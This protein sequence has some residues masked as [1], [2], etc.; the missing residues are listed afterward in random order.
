MTELYIEDY[1][2][3]IAVFGNTKEYK[4]SLKLL[5]GKYNGN[6]GGKP[7]WIFRTQDRQKVENF[8]SSIN[9]AD[10]EI[11]ASE[12]PLTKSSTGD[13]DKQITRLSMTLASFS[14]EPEKIL[15]HLTHLIKKTTKL[16]KFNKMTS[17]KQG[18]KA[19]DSD[20]DDVVASLWR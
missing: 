15:A 16:C 5:G 4:D 17:K 18:K 14:D 13:I 19:D 7:G 11:K 12:K 3:A 20:T 10:I 2:K 1:K 6:L 8:I 9:S